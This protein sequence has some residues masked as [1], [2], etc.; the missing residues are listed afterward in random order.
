MATVKKCYQVSCE[1][2]VDGAYC[3]ACEVVISVDGVCETYWP[4]IEVNAN[5]TLD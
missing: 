3:D 5:E 1:C 4:K 2:N